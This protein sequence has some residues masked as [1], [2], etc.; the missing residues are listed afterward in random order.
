MVGYKHSSSCYCIITQAKLKIYSRKYLN[1]Q[2]FCP[3]KGY[4]ATDGA[5]TNDRGLRHPSRSL[6]GALLHVQ[7]SQ[8]FVHHTTQKH[9]MVP[10]RTAV[11]DKLP[12]QIIRNDSADSFTQSV[13]SNSSLATHH[14]RKCRWSQL[15]TSTTYMR[16]SFIMTVACCYCYFSLFYELFLNTS[17]IEND[18]LYLE[19][20]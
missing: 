7:P 20:W 9:Q 2:V 16:C 1:E 14:E 19:I 4:L 15:C 13:L 10:P 3:L 8:H 6:R 17:D 11:D 12:L 5:A 18:N